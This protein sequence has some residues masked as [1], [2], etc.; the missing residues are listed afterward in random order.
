M[1]CLRN[2]G[3]DSISQC[4]F[5]ASVDAADDFDSFFR[6]ILHQL[7]ENLVSYL[8]RDKVPDTRYPVS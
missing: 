8:P 4:F 3:K 5:L 1:V 2:K 7:P 6:K